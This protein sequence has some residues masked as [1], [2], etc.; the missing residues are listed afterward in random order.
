MR[1]SSALNALPSAT[2]DI[3]IPSTVLSSIS[4]GKERHLNAN[5]LCS[6]PERIISPRGSSFEKSHNSEFYPF[7]LAYG[8]RRYF[9]TVF[10]PAPTWSLSPQSTRQYRTPPL[11][12][13]QPTYQPTYRYRVL[14]YLYVCIASWTW[15]SDG[16]CFWQ[17]N[18]KLV[19]LKRIYRVIFD[20]AASAFRLD[21]LNLWG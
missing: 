14:K 15:I 12:I 17:Y 2:Y 8:I 19:G 5:N 6:R 13:D 10:I 4:V 21:N 20:S 3:P 7:W 1:H 9:G 11:M 16:V 18:F